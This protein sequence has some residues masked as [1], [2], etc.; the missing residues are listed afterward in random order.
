MS[1][2]WW[3]HLRFSKFGHALHNA[4]QNAQVCNKIKSHFKEHKNKLSYFDFFNHVEFDI[5]C[6]LKV[7]ESD[8]LETRLD[9]LG[10]AYI[11]YWEFVEFCDMYEVDIGEQ[12]RPDLDTEQIMQEKLNVSYKD[13]KLTKEDYFNGQKTILTS[14]KAALAKCNSIWEF[15]MEK[16]ALGSTQ[17][18]LDKD[19]GPLRDSDLERCKFTLYKN[20]EP[21]KKGYA[22]PRNVVFAWADELC[23]EKGLKPQF[24]D[25]GASS[26]D[27]KQGA[28]G[29][30][31]LIS[32][33]SVLAERDELLI[34][35]RRGME[36]D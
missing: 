16:R 2:E 12:E 10:L 25:D 31:W 9:R 27:C 26:N 34:G 13:Y 24:V 28:L 21:P 20:G 11:D 35:G 33:M 36:Y 30:C 14:E 15:Y 4:L 8:A 6:N 23:K 7:W 32:A 29:D 3:E 17:K 22:D 5:K 19:F 1:T 18:Y